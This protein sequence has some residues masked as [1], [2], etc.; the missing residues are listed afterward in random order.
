MKISQL[1]LILTLFGATFDAVAGCT[2]Y[3]SVKDREG[4]TLMEVATTISIPRDTPNGTVIYESPSTRFVGPSSFTC[5]ESSFW[6]MK[7]LRGSEA[8]NSADHPIGD[9][10]IAWRF[11]Y[12]GK[13]LVKGYAGHYVFSGPSTFDQSSN[14]IQLIKVGEI[15]SGTNIPEGDLGYVKVDALRVFTIR[16]TKST[17]VVSQSCETPDV[18]APM[19]ER[20]LSTFPKSGSY[21]SPT[22]FYI[23]LNNCP[24]GINKVTYSL[25]PTSTAPA[26]NASQGIIALNGSSTAKG[27]ALQIIDSNQMPIELGKA[28]VFNGY[29]TTGGNFKIPLAARYFRTLPTGGAGVLDPGLSAGSANTEVTFIMSYL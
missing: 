27:I 8:S 29:S 19:G 25:T 6:G 17:A 4:T 23:A 11:K 20:D 1:I 16:T 14:N 18:K 24:A 9:T 21:S 10:G 26:L 28:Y 13:T 15:K 5:T 3:N 22:N 7:N 12:N 2:F